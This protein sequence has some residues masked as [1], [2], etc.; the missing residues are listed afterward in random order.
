[1]KEKQTIT[2]ECIK[3]SFPGVLAVDSV[4]LT[5]E[6]GQVHAIVGEN[7]AG[8]STLMKILAGVYT[9]DTGRIYTNGVEVNIEKPSDAIKLGISIIEQEFSLFSELNVFQNIFLGK[10]HLRFGRMLIDWTKIRRETQKILTEMG[11]NI[12]R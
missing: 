8:K 5:L 11:F 3:K 6:N 9:K 7:G 4:D 12:D 1:M 2:M 10:E